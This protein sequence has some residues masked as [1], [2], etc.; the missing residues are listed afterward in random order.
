MKRHGYNPNRIITISEGRLNKFVHGGLKC[1]KDSH[2]HIEIESARKRI[3]N[4][5]IVWSKTHHD[6]RLQQAI[7]ALYSA[8]GKQK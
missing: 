5:I 1:A 6:S 3:M 7:D 8:A 2:G 4:P